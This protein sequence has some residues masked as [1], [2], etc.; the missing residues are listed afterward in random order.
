MRRAVIA[1]MAIGILGASCTAGRIDPKATIVIEGTVMR[2]KGAREVLHLASSARVPTTGA[3]TR[4]PAVTSPARR[5][6]IGWFVVIAGM[7][8]GAVAG[9]AGLLVARDR[10][11]GVF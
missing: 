8:L 2:Q 6:G 3:G 11:H 5:H 7:I 9:A 10:K 4:A 1:A